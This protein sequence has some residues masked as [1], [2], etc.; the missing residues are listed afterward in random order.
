MCENAGAGKG[1][2][3]D[4]AGELMKRFLRGA[5]QSTLL[6]ECVDDFIDES[7]PVRIRLRRCAEYCRVAL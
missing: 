3:D 6:P 4:F 2:P 5:T 1:S 7:N